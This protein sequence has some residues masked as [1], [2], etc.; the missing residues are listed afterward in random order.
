[1]SDPDR[2][3][4]LDDDAVDAALGAADLA[5][6]VRDGD[7]LRRSLRFA[8]FVDAFGFLTR[9]A[10]IAERLF[11]HPEWSNVYNRVEIAITNHDAGGLTELDLEFVRRVNALVP[12]P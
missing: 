3:T 11:H 5:G 2:S 8:D 1:M 6:W 10:M 12:D 9:V 7:V 4:V